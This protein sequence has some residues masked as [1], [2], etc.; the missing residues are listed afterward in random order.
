MDLDELAKTRPYQHGVDL[1]TMWVQQQGARSK[2]QGAKERN[3]LAWND[4]SS[5]ER[6][7]E[8]RE[9]KGKENPNKRRELKRD[10]K[11][12]HTE[13]DEACVLLHTA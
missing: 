6:K 12:G 7:K 4:S 13:G 3:V 5:K 8:G 9:G 11:R 2:E 1:G 10:K